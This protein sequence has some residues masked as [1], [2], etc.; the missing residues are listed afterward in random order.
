MT[1]YTNTMDITEV[2][3]MIATVDSIIRAATSPHFNPAA[4]PMFDHGVCY[5][6]SYAAGLEREQLPYH[7]TSE[8]GV[9]WPESSGDLLYPVPEDSGL[10]RWEGRNREMRISLLNHIRQ[11]LIARVCVPT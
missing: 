2:R 5:A 6:I 4:D 11:Q 1:Y 9:T 8:L 3:T 10:E 7:V